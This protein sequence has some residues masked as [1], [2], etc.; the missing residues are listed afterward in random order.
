MLGRGNRSVKN[1]ESFPVCTFWKIIGSLIALEGKR[2][3]VFTLK[4]GLKDDVMV[5]EKLK[6][7][8][9][10]KFYRIMRDLGYVAPDSRFNAARQK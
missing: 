5:F 10:E 1:G 9:F 2:Y 6:G 8:I 7:A 4:N 3:E